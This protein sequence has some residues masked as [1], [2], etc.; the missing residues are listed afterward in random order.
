MK[1]TLYYLR[2]KLEKG[3]VAYFKIEDREIKRVIKYTKIDGLYIHYKNRKYTESEF[4]FSLSNSNKNE[5][6]Q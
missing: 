5:G 1:P 4:D 2:G 6:L 3:G